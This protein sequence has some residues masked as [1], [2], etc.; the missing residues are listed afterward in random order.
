M[1]G[2]LDLSDFQDALKPVGPPLRDPWA[3]PGVSKSPGGSSATMPGADVPQQRVAR[4]SPVVYLLVGLA[5]VAVLFVGVRGLLDGLTI[6]RDEQ[7]AAFV[8]D[9]VDTVEARDLAGLGFVLADDWAWDGAD[10]QGDSRQDKALAVLLTE[11]QD[12]REVS[13]A[14]EGL[15]QTTTPN[16]AHIRA[17]LVLTLRTDDGTLRRHADLDGW[18]H[19]SDEAWLV[20][21][22][23][24]TD[25]R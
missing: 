15:E 9:C 18:L 23:E 20:S 6:T 8:Q 25:I 22:V 3:V 13:L 10:P 16:N 11:I 17:G 2:S 7:V 4:I 19:A 12:A 21:S 14:L 24:I 1:A 5:A